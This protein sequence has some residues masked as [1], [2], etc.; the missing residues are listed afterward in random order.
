[1]NIQR[2]VCLV[3][4]GANIAELDAELEKRIIELTR[5]PGSI[6]DI[7]FSMSIRPYVRNVRTAS[8]EVRVW[9]A[10]VEVVL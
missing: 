3:V 2:R 7:S 4:H 6:D 8:G 1:M 10:E 9:E 5:D